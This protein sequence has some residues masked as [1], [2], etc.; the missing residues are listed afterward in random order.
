M[1]AGLAAAQA[2]DRCDEPE[3]SFKCEPCDAVIMLR[4]SDGVLQGDWKVP[5]AADA[6][7]KDVEHP[8]VV[9]VWEYDECWA[10]SANYVVHVVDWEGSTDDIDSDFERETRGTFACPATLSTT[11][12]VRSPPVRPEQDIVGPYDV[13]DQQRDAI[14]MLIDTSTLASPNAT[15]F[16]EDLATMLNT[17]GAKPTPVFDAPP[18]TAFLIGPRHLLTVAH[19][20]APSP[21]ACGGQ[22]SDRLDSITALFDYR[23]TLEAATRVTGLTVVAC[24][25]NDPADVSPETD[26]AV[27]ELDTPQTERTAF[28]L[29]PAGSA[30][31]PCAT[32]YTLGH[33][34]GHPQQCIGTARLDRPTAWVMAESAPALRGTFTTSLDVLHSL[35][36][37]PVFDRESHS[38]IG[39][40]REGAY[41]TGGVFRS[42]AAK[43]TPLANCGVE[44]NLGSLREELDAIIAD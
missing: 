18:A 24:G 5:A 19:W 35:S 28:T 14:A 1:L 3:V 6:A 44:L 40:H 27:L 9:D 38:L 7:C 17:T 31:P 2:C 34:L 4:R 29:P 12:C 15:A 10:E 8:G 23:T 11:G 25:R 41:D 30:P 39:L 21:E 26:W 13:C 32:V 36:G 33:P 20:L 43:C 16:A 22:R 37:A 42:P